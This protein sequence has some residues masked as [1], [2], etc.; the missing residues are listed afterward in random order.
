MPTKETTIFE[1]A[2]MALRTIAFNRGVQLLQKSGDSYWEGP[3]MWQVRTDHENVRFFAHD[4]ALRWATKQGLPVGSIAPVKAHYSKPHVLQWY[5][6]QKSLG[7]NVGSDAQTICSA[8]A[9]SVDDMIAWFN[10]IQSFDSAAA[11]SL[12]QL[13]F[14]ANRPDVTDAIAKWAQGGPSFWF[15][16]SRMS[17]DISDPFARRSDNLSQMCLFA[18]CLS[19]VHLL[20]WLFEHQL[21]LK[22]MMFEPKVWA[23]LQKG[24]AQAHTDVRAL[25]PRVAHKIFEVNASP[26]DYDEC[27]KSVICSMLLHASFSYDPAAQCYLAYNMLRHPSGMMNAAPDSCKNLDVKAF[28]NKLLALQHREDAALLPTTPIADKLM[29]AVYLD[30]MPVDFYQHAQMVFTQAKS[31]ERDPVQTAIDPGVFS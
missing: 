17:G 1:R 9:D 19:N 2:K 4:T 13:G 5:A 20:E 23:E 3:P 15:N 29:V 8:H 14:A 24:L 18:R 25:W 16:G 27:Q 28:H 21:H 31:P 30:Q 12:L 6:K 10:S 7:M 22:H 26:L 11:F